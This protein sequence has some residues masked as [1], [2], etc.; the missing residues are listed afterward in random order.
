MPSANPESRNR[1]SI[2][3]YGLLSFLLFSASPA[4]SQSLPGF[5]CSSTEAESTFNSELRS[6]T[7]ERTYSLRTL[8]NPQE[9]AAAQSGVR[10][11]LFGKIDAAK[12]GF[13][14]VKF[15]VRVTPPSADKDT[16]EHIVHIFVEVAGEQSRWLEVVAKEEK[17]L[18]DLPAPGDSEP[19]KPA[20]VVEVLPATGDRAVPLF[21]L[22]WR[23]SEQSQWTIGH[24]ISLLLDLR[25]AA[26]SIAAEL[27]CMSVTAFGACGVY[28][29]QMQDSTNHQCQWDAEKNDF[30]CDAATTSRT[31]WTTR[32]FHEH[33]LLLQH[34]NLPPADASGGPPDL[35][36]FAKLIEKDPSREKRPAVLPGIGETHHLARFGNI[37][38]FAARGI[39]SQLSARFFYAILQEDP[40]V[41]QLPAYSFFNDQSEGNDEAN[42]ASEKKKVADSTVKLLRALPTGAPLQFDTKLLSK[43]GG[44]SIYQV[45]VS[46]GGAHSL[47]WLGAEEKQKSGDVSFSV[48]KISTDVQTYSGCNTSASEAG[49]ASVR[50]LKGAKTF[51]AVV[52]VEPG[53]KTSPDGSLEQPR[54]NAG[55]TDRCPYRITLFWDPASGYFDYDE[56]KQKTLC[57]PDY[58][59]RQLVIAKDGSVSTK[60][61]EGAGAN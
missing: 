53:H 18:A 61:F 35:V 21:T 2:I 8:S 1:L 59:P 17:L 34:K 13:A 47:Y 36:E 23:H 37:H 14:R 50:L 19:Q 52:E 46:E 4:R 51:Q 60:P 25:P 29:A 5:G 12:Y 30:R 15:Y 45:L 32:V 7:G 33:F 16:R 38:L 28:D 26:A 58:A 31:G 56:K 39:E 22:T 43:I 11:M 27:D 20:P 57:R 41:G 55:D 3:S 42:N 49:A 48:L 44:T 6:G 24:E 54:E 9:I 10:P 40:D